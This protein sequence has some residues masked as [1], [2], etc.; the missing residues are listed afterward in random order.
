MTGNTYA[1]RTAVPW[2]A[3]FGAPLVGI[4]VLVVLLAVGGHGRSEAAPSEVETG[5]VSE[6]AEA[7]QAGIEIPHVLFD[8]SAE[9]RV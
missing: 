8:E 6:R 2:W 3:A 4:P 1:A 7:L 5:Y 9:P